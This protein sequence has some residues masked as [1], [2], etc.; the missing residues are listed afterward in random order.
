MFNIETAQKLSKEFNV[1]IEDILCI[2]LNKF[3]I[4]ANINDNRTRFKL[5]LMYYNAK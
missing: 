1:P 3:G 2:A 4:R 5:Q